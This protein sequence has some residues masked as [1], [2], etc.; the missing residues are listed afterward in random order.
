MAEP[1]PRQA[2]TAREIQA[3][4]EA[5]SKAMVDYRV[6]RATAAQVSNADRRL[7]RAHY[8]AYLVSAGRPPDFRGPD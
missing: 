3:A 1:E 2:A 7:A 4:T 6:G 8:D 5:V